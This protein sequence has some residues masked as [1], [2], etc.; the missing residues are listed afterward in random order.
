[1]CAGLG[2]CQYFNSYTLSCKKPRRIPCPKEDASET[3]QEVPMTPEEKASFNDF[4]TKLE[5]GY[6]D[7][8]FK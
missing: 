8:I 3:E 7:A 5:A 2:Y 4:L 1:M 6:F